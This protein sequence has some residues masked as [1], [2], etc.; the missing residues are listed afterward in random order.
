VDLELTRKTTELMPNL[1]E[2]GGMDKD[3][4]MP[5]PSVVAVVLNYRHPEDALRCVRTLRK[6]DY[7]QLHI[8]VVDNASPDSSY[9]ALCNA[10]RG[11]SGA[12]V[13]QCK[14]NGGYAMGNN[15][16]VRHAMNVSHPKYILVANPDVEFIEDNT[17]RK[18]VACAE[19]AE[20]AGVVAPKVVFP[21]GY[22]QGPC[23][24]P[25]LWLMALQYLIPPLWLVV[26]WF[27]QRRS[28]MLRVPTKVFRTV[29][30]CMLLVVEEFCKVGMFDEG[31]FLEGEED[32]LAE[33]LGAISKHFYY[34]PST[35]VVH[36]HSRRQYKNTRAAQRYYFR[37]YRGKSQLAISL[38]MLSSLYYEHLVYP[39]VRMIRRWKLRHSGSEPTRTLSSPAT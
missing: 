13:I 9:D 27:A 38:L 1:S 17:V 3:L 25:R 8:L 16:G 29:G 6:Q 26:R 36:H 20:D 18:L 14:V 33:R 35:T 15:F 4:L 34:L 28:R 22:I 39:F 31:T 23:G 12:S 21:D 24:R 37:K 2:D 5:M 32:I 30:A 7:A 10:L 19:A 11:E